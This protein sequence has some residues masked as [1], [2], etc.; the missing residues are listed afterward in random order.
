MTNI[1]TKIGL[2]E[3]EAN[4][5]LSFQ[6]K[7]EK[8]ASF[9]AKMINMDK[10]SCYRA[11]ESLV[12]KSL[13]IAIPKKRGTTYSAASPKLLKELLAQKEQQLEQEKGALDMFVKSLLTDSEERATSI[14]IEKGIEAVRNAMDATL[15]A[16]I[17][18]KTFIRERYRLNA[19]YFQDPV[20]NDWV[21]NVFFKKRIKSGI[22]IKQIVDFSDNHVFDPIMKTDQ[23]LLKEI[24]LMP[25]SVTDPNSMRVAGDFVTITSFDKQ[26]DYIVITIKD[27]YVAALIE[28]MFDFMWEHTDP[29][30]G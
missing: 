10:S 20:H 17:R 8:T 18:N 30:T 9:I 3:N 16:A 15:E 19:P 23:K 11:V 12:S 13:L 1:L 21:T 24:H 28:S 6:K 14:H 22:A 5:Y 4:V 29:Y 26:N 7:G 25:N 27:K 2:T